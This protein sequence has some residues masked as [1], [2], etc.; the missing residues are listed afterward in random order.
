M[1]ARIYHP[2]RV[3][4]RPALRHNAASYVGL[5]TMLGWNDE[6]PVYLVV[7]EIT[8]HNLTHR[9]T[10]RKTRANHI[11]WTYNRR[12]ATRLSLDGRT[13]EDVRRFIGHERVATVC[14]FSGGSYPL[15]NARNHAF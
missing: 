1:V 6:D 7:N 15:V 10:G 8:N 4:N 3:P 9:Y 2:V 13:L 14:P 5:V 11:G 12:M